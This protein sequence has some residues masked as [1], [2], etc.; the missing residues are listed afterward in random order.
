M[1]NEGTSGITTNEVGFGRKV[2]YEKQQTK[3]YYE[4]LLDSTVYIIANNSYSA[5]APSD[6]TGNVTLQRLVPSAYADGYEAPSGNTRP[7]ARVISNAVCAQAGNVLVNNPKN[8]T[9]IFWVW[10]QY[11]DHDLDLTKTIADVNFNIAV[12]SG[13]EFFDPGSTGNV[14]ITLHRSQFADGTS[15]PGTPREQISE[16]TSLLDATNVYGST[17]ERATWLRTFKDGKLKTS[18]GGMLPIT[19]TMDNDGPANSRVFG[20]GDIRANEN[21]ALTSV[22]NLFVKEHNWWAAKIKRAKRS[23]TD[24]QIYQKARMMVES[25]IQAIT[26]NEFLPLLL[27]PDA[28]PAY[29]STTFDNTINTNIANEFAHSAY[30]FGHSLVSET[31]H[32]L[33]SK[34][35]EISNGHLTLRDAFFAPE[36]FANE[37]SIDYILRGVCTKLCQKLDTKVVESLRNFLFGE[38]G[39]GGHDLASLN[40]QRGRDHGFPDYNT[41]RVA[42]GLAAKATF[43]EITSDTALASA[44]ST[45]YGGDISLI[46]P[47]VGGLSEDAVT[48]SQLGELFHKIVG[49][50]FLRTRN[51]DPMWY[52]R[53]LSK[54]PKKLVELTKLSTIIKRNT[55]IS[56][57]RKYVMTNP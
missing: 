22:H 11:V 38:P 44:L 15:V 54:T 27:G 57:L 34:G 30:R 37:G 9:D 8:C 5:R 52:Q 40:I 3:S 20:A 48:G 41:M 47:W 23:L 50:Q 14:E 10:G 1:S 31:L 36:K 39:S 21:V 29:T 46:D 33:D 43:A 51:G 12:P 13:D 28:I 17:T 32:R 19:N 18:E 45:A 53:R 25:E 6:F 42:L 26:F 4:R 55:K 2:Y 49:D 35:E 56:K 7:S 24:E 16:V